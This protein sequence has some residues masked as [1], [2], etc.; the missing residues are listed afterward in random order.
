MT[1]EVV[2][3]LLLVTELD[4]QKKNVRSQSKELRMESR[5]AQRRAD[6]KKGN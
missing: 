6:A 1:L 4:K 2:I 3:R 5:Q